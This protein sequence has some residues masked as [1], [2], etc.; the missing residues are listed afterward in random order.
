M[1]AIADRSRRGCESHVGPGSP[2][3][4]DAGVMGAIAT[5]GKTA[6][7]PRRRRIPEGPKRID[8]FGLGRKNPRPGHDRCSRG[9]M[10]FMKCLLSISLLLILVVPLRAEV[11]VGDKPKLKIPAMDGS[12]IDLEIGRASC[13]E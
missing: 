4:A 3:A 6:A 1:R 13:R 9:K 10:S 11:L 12:P 8:R 5:H 7:R 2:H